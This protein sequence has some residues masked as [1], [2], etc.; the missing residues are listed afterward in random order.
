MDHDGGRTIS[1]DAKAPGSQ[2]P[3]PRAIRSRRGV[4]RASAQS[5]P[6]V[7]VTRV[8]VL[9]EDLELAE[10]VPAADLPRAQRATWATAI[11]FESGPIDI[12]T[13]PFS[14]TVFALV[15]VK[16]VLIRQ[17]SLSTQAMIEVLIPGDVVFPWSPSP[18]APLTATG[19]TAVN[20]VRVAVLDQAF[21]KAAAAWPE[22]M[23]AIQQ[24]LSDQQHR[25]ATHG[26]ICQ[27]PRI[28]QRVMAVMWLLAARMGTV[29]P[30]GTEL[31]L[32]L[33]HQALAQLTG[34]RRPTVSLAIKRLREYGYLE[35]RAGGAW[36]LPRG[37]A[38]VAFED[39]VANLDEI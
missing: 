14:P 13:A 7:T 31:S 25:L 21:V 5:R 6:G 29:T 36:L 26:A 28:E 19:L 32:R 38:M 9:A 23:V 24:R 12:A 33:T 20:E 10:A 17:T 39:L 30:A 27:L 15:V 22:L 35:R 4:R 11:T 18:T 37:P 8:S 34:A 1:L 16:G 2:G 3:V